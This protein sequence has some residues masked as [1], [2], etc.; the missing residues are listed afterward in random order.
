[1]TAQP[2]PRLVAYP[3]LAVLSAVTWAIVAGVV[4][5]LWLLVRPA[6]AQTPATIDAA[7]QCTE[8]AGFGYVLVDDV[9]GLAWTFTLGQTPQAI[10]GASVTLDMIL[11]PLGS[12]NRGNGEIVSPAGS[13]ICAAMVGLPASGRVRLAVRYLRP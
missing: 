1:M 4:F 9:D 7:Y 13:G 8:S 5:G 3:I 11:W 6:F 10:A 12:F 2:L